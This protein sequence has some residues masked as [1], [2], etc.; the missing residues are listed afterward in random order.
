[1]QIRAEGQSPLSFEDEEQIVSKEQ[2]YRAMYRST[3]SKARPIKECSPIGQQPFILVQ[4]FITAESGQSQVAKGI[5]QC[6][7]GETSVSQV[8][9]CSATRGK[10]QC[11][12][13]ETVDCSKSSSRRYCC[14]IKVFSGRK[15]FCS[16]KGRGQLSEAVG[17]VGVDRRRSQVVTWT[18]GHIG[19]HLPRVT[20]L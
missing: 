19:P 12:G 9:N 4:L 6:H 10:L 1:M 16:K 2:F 18:G 17:A 7:T 13:Q 3:I 15:V 20:R 8:R 5:L 14:P 11:H